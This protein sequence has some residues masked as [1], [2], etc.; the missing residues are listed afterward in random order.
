MSK[1]ADDLLRQ[2]LDL[3][4]AERAEMA[5]ALLQSLEPPPDAEVD[6]A[7]REEVQR[8]LRDLDAGRG[9][10]VPWEEVREQ[11]FARLNDRS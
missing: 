1:K 2:A 5:G 10:M 11:L 3:E 8:R 4:E 7:W 9:Q 6:S